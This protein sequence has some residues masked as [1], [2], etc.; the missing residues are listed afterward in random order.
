MSH[1]CLIL[2]TAGKNSSPRFEAGAAGES[3]MVGGDV[4]TFSLYRTEP[5]LHQSRQGC[6][7]SRGDFRFPTAPQ[8]HLQHGNRLLWAGY[9][10]RE[11]HV[12]SCALTV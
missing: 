4:R 5:S 1:I 9:I 3:Q 2:I 7:E 10:Y 11:S 6:G 12:I 8:R